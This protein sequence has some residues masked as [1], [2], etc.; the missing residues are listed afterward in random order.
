MKRV[1]K[2]SWIEDHMEEL[3][4]EFYGWSDEYINLVDKALVSNG[5][6]RKV[7][8]TYYQVFDDSNVR[9]D[10]G[11]YTIT[12]GLY[13][14]KKTVSVMVKDAEDSVRYDE[15]IAEYTESTI[16]KAFEEAVHDADYWG[17]PE[18]V[19]ENLYESIR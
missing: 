5:F 17:L 10:G 13:P 15:D 7:D 18:S 3:D 6:H 4:D 2:S 19:C 11:T 9:E 1:I 16:R 8:Q 12:F 14:E